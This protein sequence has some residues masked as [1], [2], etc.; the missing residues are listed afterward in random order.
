MDFQ[1]LVSVPSLLAQRAKG[2]TRVG[3]QA[4]ATLGLKVPMP[5]GNAM[6]ILQVEFKWYN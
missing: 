4:L 6:D 3:W 5:E 2:G 1:I